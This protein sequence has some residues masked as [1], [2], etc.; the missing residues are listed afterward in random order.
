MVRVSSLSFGSVIAKLT[1]VFLITMLLFSG[2]QSKKKSGAANKMAEE[3]KNSTSMPNRASLRHTSDP[4]TVWD[5]DYATING[6]KI[7]GYL[8]KPAGKTNGMPGIIVIHEWWG[9]NGNIKNMT[10]RL[11]GQGYVAL[12]VDLYHGK[13]ATQAK[14]AMKLMKTAMDHKQEDI[15]NLKQAYRYLKN[16]E[17]VEKTGVIGWCFGGGWA[18]RTALALPDSIDATAIYYGELTTN[19]QKL[20]T[21]QMPLIGFFGGKDKSI[22]VKTVN[23][24]KTTLDSLGKQVEIKIYPDAHHAFANPSGGTRYNPQAADDA[25]GKTLAFFDKYL[26]S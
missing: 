10:R 18:L 6:K 5:V 23:Q 14:D 25:W 19:P 1:G 15:E 13:T 11:A 24:F 2:C 9:L 8:A 17:H 16:T 12:A 22:P 4:V 26:K 21:L 7:R 20:K 3:H